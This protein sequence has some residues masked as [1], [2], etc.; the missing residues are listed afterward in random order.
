MKNKTMVSE[1]DMQVVLV[2]QV[3]AGQVLGVVVNMFFRTIPGS[4]TG[5]YNN[6]GIPQLP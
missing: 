3:L 5:M 4:A 1:G 6:L 2:V